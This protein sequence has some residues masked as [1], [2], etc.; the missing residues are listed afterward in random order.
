MLLYAIHTI[1]LT[2]ISNT[3]KP[4]FGEDKS[5]NEQVKSRSD[6][7]TFVL[8]VEHLLPNIINYAL[9]KKQ[10]SDIGMPH[11]L[12]IITHTIKFMIN[13]SQTV[14][15]ICLGLKKTNIPSNSPFNK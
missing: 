15:Y 14:E 7:K 6:T 13:K 2:L 5:Y 11:P 10:H 12:F 3:E 4:G 9:G 1:T 8:L